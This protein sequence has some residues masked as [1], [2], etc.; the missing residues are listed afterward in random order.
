MSLN[1]EEWVSKLQQAKR[2]RTPLKA[3]TLNGE[4]IS[5][6]D[7]YGVQADLLRVA[8]SSG[9]KLSG[10]KMGLTS[11]AKQREMN[12]FEPIRGFLLSSMRWDVKKPMPLGK[13]IHP[14][15]EPEIAI[16]MKNQLRGADVTLE[17]VEMAIDKVVIAIEVLD[18]RYEKYQFGLADVI[19]DNTSAAHYVLSEKNLISSEGPMPL[20]GILFYKNSELIA[21][22][23][24]AASLGSPLLAVQSLVHLLAKQGNGIDAGMTIMTGG[25]TA[26]VA[27]QPGDLLEVRCPHDLMTLQFE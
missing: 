26:S 5:L 23:S 27:V 2:S 16:V 17:D 11:L 22:G 18:S 13:M 24:P 12:V 1:R 3:P 14:R 25:I 21:T 20:W 6:D 19:M 15:A 9:E 7:A 8:L 4:S 10:Y